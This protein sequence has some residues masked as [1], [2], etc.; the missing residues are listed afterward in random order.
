MY[1]YTIESKNNNIIVH[2]TAVY[3]VLAFVGTTSTSTATSSNI[4]MIYNIIILII[5][6]CTY[7]MY[8][9]VIMYNNI[10]IMLH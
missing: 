2:S 9:V 8:V 3:P 6:S 10:Y 1:M 7:V 4:I 5:L